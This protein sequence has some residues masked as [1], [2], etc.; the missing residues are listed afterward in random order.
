MQLP[1]RPRNGA[2]GSPPDLDGELLQT[3]MRHHADLLLTSMRYYMYL[4]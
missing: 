3:R 2:R 4:L 1:E